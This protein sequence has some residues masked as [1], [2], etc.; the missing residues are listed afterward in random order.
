LAQ[1]ARLDLSGLADIPEIDG[2]LPHVAANV[3]HSNDWALGML[4][5]IHHTDALATNA[6]RNLLYRGHRIEGTQQM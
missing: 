6:Q 1:F 2:P 5:D 3:L 4:L